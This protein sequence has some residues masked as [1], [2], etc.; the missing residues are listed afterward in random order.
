MKG[1]PFARPLSRPYGFCASAQVTELEQPSRGDEAGGPFTLTSMSIA[2][3]REAVNAIPRL[4]TQHFGT[5]RVW[6]GLERSSLNPSYQALLGRLWALSSR[7]PLS[8]WHSSR[9][10]DRGAKRLKGMASLRHPALKPAR[11]SR[12]APWASKRSWAIPGP[13]RGKVERLK[14]G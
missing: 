2:V 5:L 1:S 8:S 12:E 7:A 11:T 10:P 4:S 13:G 9:G 3:D 14:K 6:Q